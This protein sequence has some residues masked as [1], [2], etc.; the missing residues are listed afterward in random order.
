ML[1]MILIRA[2]QSS[3]KRRT[4]SDT[5]RKAMDEYNDAL[6][7]AGV[8]VMAK[9]LHP[10]SDALRFNYD[11]ESK[12]SQ[13]IL[14]P[15]SSESL[16]AG[17]FLIEVKNHEEAIYWAQQCPDPIGMGEGEIELRQVL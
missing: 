6:E 11:Q 1:F 8:K 14:G 4:P 17:F 15:F 2:S 7:R 13:A 3:E 16:I 12:I 9:G 10:S 5:L